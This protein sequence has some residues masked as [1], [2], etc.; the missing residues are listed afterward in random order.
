MLC[1]TPTLTLSGHACTNVQLSRVISG[2]SQPLPMNTVSTCS[3]IINQLLWGATHAH[4][5][6]HAP[7]SGPPT[8]N[9]HVHYAHMRARIWSE[10]ASFDRRL[11]DTLVR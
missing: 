11:K 3:V 10:L 4:L 7:Y 5:L 1:I 8:T 9:T 6:P 2:V